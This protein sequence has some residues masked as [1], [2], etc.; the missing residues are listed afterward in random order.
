MGIAAADVQKHFDS[1]PDQFAN[2]EEETAWI[3]KGQDLVD[4]MD[5]ADKPTAFIK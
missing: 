5:I 1:R 2:Q 3:S 4:N